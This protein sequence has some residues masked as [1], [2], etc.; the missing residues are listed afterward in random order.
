MVLRA[1]GQAESDI[2]HTRR[3]GK[4]DPEAQAEDQQY[5][6]SNAARNNSGKAPSSRAQ[7]GADAAAVHLD[8][9]A[10]D[11]PGVEEHT[12]HVVAGAAQ[13]EELLQLE[14]PSDPENEP[15]I[16][17]QVYFQGSH[18]PITKASPAAANHNGLSQE[19]QFKA[20]H[21][22]SPLSPETLQQPDAASS[23]SSSK[24]PRRI[25]AIS[26]VDVG[27]SGVQDLLDAYACLCW[28]ASVVEL[29][30]ALQFIRDCIK[31]GRK[32][33]LTRWACQFAGHRKCR[34]T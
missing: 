26:D 8:V 32:D 20:R 16:P 30:A 25:I 21:S 10:G 33:V 11:P 22:M 17:K 19:Q 34:M 29:D 14:A 31:H 5:H 24:G 12:S 2:R 3:K 27:K 7:S 23:S 1:D 4:A 15:G 6:G 28:N 13:L 9:V 18:G